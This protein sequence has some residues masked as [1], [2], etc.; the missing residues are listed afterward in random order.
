M[1]LRVG[2]VLVVT[3]ACLA[4][5]LKGL[6]YRVFIDSLAHFDWRAMLVAQALYV[7][8]H[9]L[10]AERFRVLLPVTM[11]RR[12][13]LSVL[14][15]GYL[16]LHVIPL[17]LGELVRPYLA[18]ERAGVPFG[19]SLAVVVMERIL[20]VTMLLLMLF[21]VAWFVSL[22]AS[23]VVNGI[24]LLAVGQKG[25]GIAVGL[26]AIGLLAVGVVG[27]P[28]VRLFDKTP[29]ARLAR[30]FH[31]AIAG[32]RSRPAAGA[33]ALAHSVAIWAIT[34]LAVKVQLAGSPGLP[35]TLGAALTTWT[36][37]LAGMAALPTPGF[38][39]G[40]EA[41]C[42]AALELQGVGPSE[43]RT[44][45]ILLHVGQFAFTVAVGFGFLMAEGLSLREVVAKSQEA[46]S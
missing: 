33:Q 8:A 7:V 12:T 39:G 40:F 42:A 16:A 14:S 30:S 41:A 45:G 21:S 31:D 13:T 5:V 19:A 3:L 20:D 9:L 29:V 35:A 26:G 36:A 37:T 34:I 23:I 10:R 38:F 4:W 2:L 25:A 43:A 22:P 15:V 44:F 46:A 18:R 24:D 11:S 32:L 6:E 27:E 1:K 28:V 17:R